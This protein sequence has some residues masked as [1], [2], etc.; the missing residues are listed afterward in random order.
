MSGGNFGF[1]WSR[2]AT[3]LGPYSSSSMGCGHWWDWSLDCSWNVTAVS[4]C[5]RGCRYSG[6]VHNRKSVCVYKCQ[7]MHTK[8]L[9]HSNIPI[10]CMY[11][12]F[13]VLT[14]TSQFRGFLT[15]LEDLP[16]RWWLGLTVVWRCSALRLSTGLGGG[17]PHK[18]MLQWFDS[19]GC[20]LP[21]RLLSPSFRH[22]CSCTFGNN[23]LL[24][25]ARVGPG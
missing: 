1:G 5:G 4:G 14:G 11:I 20:G 6:C 3:G 22:G 17:L 10:D 24:S 9:S 7:S 23:S 8:V 21:W 12:M 2:N 19:G 13:C 25:A 16:S 18:C 15:I